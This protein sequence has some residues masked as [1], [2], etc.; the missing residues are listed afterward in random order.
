MVNCLNEIEINSILFVAVLTEREDLAI[1]NLTRLTQTTPDDF[2]TYWQHMVIWR[3][4]DQLAEL[5]G[6]IFGV[7]NKPFGPGK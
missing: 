7:L 6:N 1:Y 2:Y 3:Q 5:D 4:A